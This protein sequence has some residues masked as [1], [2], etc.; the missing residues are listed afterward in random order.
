MKT[1]HWIPVSAR[2]LGRDIRT[3]AFAA[4]LRLLPALLVL[5]GGCAA[6]DLERFNQTL[7]ITASGTK[8]A[9]DGLYAYAKVRADEIARTAPSVAVGEIQLAA[10]EKEVTGAR[11]LLMAVKGL[12]V[13]GL[14]IA[15]AVKAGGAVALIK[16]W[17]PTLITAI[18]EANKALTLLGVGLPK[19][20][21]P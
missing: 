15:K 7:A 11:A 10:L 8:A 18:G 4:A 13:T 9:D 12:L 16:A 3:I 5:A 6:T 1:R 14:A 19:L 20:A 21:A 17:L 2:I